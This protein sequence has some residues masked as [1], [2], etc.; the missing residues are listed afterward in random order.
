MSLHDLRRRDTLRVSAGSLWQDSL[1]MAQSANS[2]VKHVVSPRSRT[3][4]IS[5]AYIVNEDPSVAQTEENLSLTCLGDACADVHASLNT[6]AFERIS[7][8]TTDV[9]DG[10]YNAGKCWHVHFNTACVYS[11]Y[12]TQ[13]EPSCK[14]L[15]ADVVVA[16]MSDSFCQPSLFYHL[17]VRESFG[18]TNNIILYCYKQDSD[19]QAIKV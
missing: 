9:L 10:F 11:L 16:E 4:A 12:F 18:M 2:S 17:G 1:V 15:P 13:S 6:I 5:V 19:L 3:R 7:L 14:I 8:G